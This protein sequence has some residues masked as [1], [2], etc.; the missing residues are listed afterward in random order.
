MNTQENVVSSTQAPVTASDPTPVLLTPD[1]V[2]AQLM[3]LQQQIPDFTQLQIPDAQTL[4]SAANVGPAFVRT[5]IDTVRNSDKVQS[6]LGRNP[7]DLQQ[8][9]LDADKWSSV[10]AELR[11]FLKGVSAANLLRR[12]KVGTAALQAYTIS[13]QLVRGQNPEVNLIPRIADM[14]RANRFGRKPK[15]SQTPGTPASQPSTPQPGPV[16]STQGT[17][18]P[19]QPPSPPQTHS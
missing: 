4:R 12:H 18:T 15:G 1:A 16:A 14:R 5:A 17:T 7:D 8:E 3:A 10:E 13:R 19:V 2:L 9:A 11:V 6:A